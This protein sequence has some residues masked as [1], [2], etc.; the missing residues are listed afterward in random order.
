MNVDESREV[1]YTHS[2]QYAIDVSYLHHMS[3][4]S[5]LQMYHN[6]ACFVGIKQQLHQLHHL[7]DLLISSSLQYHHST[8]SSLYNTLQQVYQLQ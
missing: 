4:M 8:I 5:M 3:I 7:T 1:I 6:R 2:R